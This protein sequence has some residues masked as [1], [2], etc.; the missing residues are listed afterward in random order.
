MTVRLTE[1]AAVL[2]RVALDM[3]LELNRD[4]LNEACRRNRLLGQPNG[5]AVA[6]ACRALDL[7][8]REATIALAHADADYR[9]EDFRE[10][11]DE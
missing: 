3:R 8:G 10:D 1:D 11:G 9:A 2:V 6:I 5:K 4:G 7:V